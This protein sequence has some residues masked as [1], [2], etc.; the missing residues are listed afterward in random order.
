[1]PEGDLHTA[2]L[3][4]KDGW[5]SGI[6]AGVVLAGRWWPGGFHA[7]WVVQPLGFTVAIDRALARIH[8]VLPAAWHAVAPH[9]H[10]GH[11]VHVR[12]TVVH[13]GSLKEKQKKKLQRKKLPKP[14][15]IC[16]QSKGE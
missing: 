1:M 14:P 12:N 5:A 15:Q 11:L 16:P 13:G 3:V 4:L 8:A 9:P 10:V 6:G 2:V 7:G